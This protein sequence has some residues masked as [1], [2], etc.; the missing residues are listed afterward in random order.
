MMRRYSFLEISRIVDSIEGWLNPPVVSLLYRLAQGLG[1]GA[2]IVEIGCWKGKS[3]L[4]LHLSQPEAVVYAIDPFTGSSEHQKVGETVDTYAEFLHNI[5]LYG[6]TEKIVVLPMRSEEAVG[7]IPDGVDMLWIDGAH[8]YESVKRDFCVYY[9]R[10]KD[11]AVIAMHDYKWPGVKGFTWELLQG[12]HGA[13]GLVRRVE[14]THYMRKQNTTY[15]VRW[16]NSLRYQFYR[17]Q[18][19]QKSLRRKFTRWY[20]T[21]N[22]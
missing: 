13:V 10:L 18:Q 16:L 21:P 2:R 11:G 1:P 9:P 15:T 5:S 20:R 4:L 8:D 14:D 6:Q 22:G 12:Q 19:K 17:L 7:K 3:T